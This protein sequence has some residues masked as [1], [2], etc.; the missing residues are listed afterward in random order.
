MVSLPITNIVLG[1]G[2]MSG[3]SYLGVL[4][5]FQEQGYLKH[6]KHC[7]G[8]SIGAFFGF[9]FASKIKIGEIE[10]VLKEAYGNPENTLCPF[11]QL[12]NIQSRFG[13]DSGERLIL[14]LK[15]IYQSYYSSLFPNKSYTIDDL[16]FL[17][18]T[19]HTGCTLTVV[20]TNVSLKQPTF[21]SVETTPNVS[22]WKAIQASMSIPSL[23]EPVQINDYY[24]V[25]GYLTCEYPSPK[26]LDKASTLGLFICT[27]SF[28][29]SS[30][31]SHIHGVVDYLTHLI[32]LI[33]F[34]PKETNRIKE[35]L[36]HCILFDENPID[37]LPIQMHPEG[38]YF[39]VS[40]SDIDLSM[41]YGYEKTYTF[42]TQLI[43]KQNQLQLQ[44]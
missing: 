18:F 19:K 4:R 15:K 44:I 14:P 25:D 35:C 28:M 20:A 16:T 33:L 31:H 13:M 12:S 26:L 32:E 8:V 36:E 27:Q 30:S 6:V 43:A 10:S 21:F 2:G 5:Y 7:Y 9:L 42:F 29:K 40:E 17:D 34:Y 3:M 11:H 1:S 23:F 38:I 37:F 41:G 39:D 24:Y 22:L